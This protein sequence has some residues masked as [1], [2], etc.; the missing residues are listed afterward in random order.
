MNTKQTLLYLLNQNKMKAYY[1]L[2]FRIYSI[3]TVSYKNEYKTINYLLTSTSTLI[4]YFTIVTVI[5]IIDFYVINFYN[6]LIPNSISVVTYM[7]VIGIISYFFI[8]KKKKFLKYNFKNDRR[9]GYLICVYLIFIA[10]LLLF[11]ANKNRERIIKEKEIKKI[12]KA[13]Y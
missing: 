12:E 9:G 11:F 10:I 5:S 7:I 8:I 3:L 13:E 2:L 4:V 1:Y 6:T